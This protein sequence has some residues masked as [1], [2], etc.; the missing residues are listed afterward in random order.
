MGNSA[1]LQNCA[2]HSTRSLC[3]LGFG[4]V[5]LHVCGD[6][7]KF[8]CRAW[9]ETAQNSTGFPNIFAWAM[10]GLIA[11]GTPYPDIWVR[12]ALQNALPLMYLP[13]GFC[14]LGSASP[15]HQ[16]MEHWQYI[17]ESDIC[18]EAAPLSTEASGVTRSE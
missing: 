2:C 14:C 3:P 8:R 5:L 4:G 9:T 18:E 15:C 17:W 1:F 10:E 7:C 13:S 12:C 16:I 11:K 6:M